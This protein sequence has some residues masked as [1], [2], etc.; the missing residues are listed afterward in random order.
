MLPHFLNYRELEKYDRI[1]VCMSHPVAWEIIHK[2]YFDAP[3][4]IGGGFGVNQTL[5]NTTSGIPFFDLA[6][7]PSI[8]SMRDV[9]IVFHGN[10]IRALEGL[11]HATLLHGELLPLVSSSNELAGFL[12]F[13]NRYQPKGCCL[14][15]GANWGINTGL[16]ADKA[17]SI[18]CFEP[19]K[20]FH[21]DAALYKFSAGRPNIQHIQKAIGD[22]TGEIEI[23]TF[24]G[25]N[26][27]HFNSTIVN[28]DQVECDVINTIEFSARETVSITTIDEFCFEH[29]LEPAFIKVDVEGAEAKVLKGARKTIEK[30]RPTLFLEM[31][32]GFF[33]KGDEWNEEMKFLDEIYNTF[34]IPC[35]GKR[36]PSFSPSMPLSEFFS[37]YG[38]YPLN[39]GFVSK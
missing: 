25:K 23:R 11:T 12:W 39:C 13:I 19:L 20:K 38:E 32:T 30:Y 3:W 14:D 6:D 17:S 37:K 34:S 27:D 24:G 7:A 22:F 1:F 8:L 28:D 31:P 4:S 35:I 29:K 10:E 21:S 9:V 26:E 16:L 2:L 15:V 33:I 5:M 18:Y 36:M